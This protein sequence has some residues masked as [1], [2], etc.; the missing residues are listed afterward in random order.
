[1]ITKK[2]LYILKYILFKKNEI[3]GGF[4]KCEFLWLATCC[5]LLVRTRKGN[6]MSTMHLSF[7]QI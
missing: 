2:Y 6:P 4:R 3:I 1:M 5:L 7:R